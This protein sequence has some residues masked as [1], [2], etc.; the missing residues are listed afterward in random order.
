MAAEKGNQYWKMR[1]KHGR[2]RE[3]QSA[4]ELWEKSCEYFQWVVDNPLMEAKA[5]SFKGES[6]I[7]SV[8]KMRTMSIKGLCLFLGVNE[9]YFNDFVSNLKDDDDDF[10]EVITT[11]KDIIHQYKLEGATADLLNANIISRELGLIDKKEIDNKSS[12]GS[13]SPA[14]HVTYEII[15]PTDE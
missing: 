14:T 1:E 6:W 15:D 4:G 7:E 2:N 8:P 5:M 11:I 9:K 12:D 13:M 10:S 3:F